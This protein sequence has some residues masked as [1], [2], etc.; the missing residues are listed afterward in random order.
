MGDIVNLRQIKKLRAR[1]ADKQV[2]AAN[3]A[4]F[5]RTLADRIADEHRTEREAT[6]L[7]GKRLVPKTVE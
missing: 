4:R 5:G 6:G 1:A 7:G 3:R 2:A